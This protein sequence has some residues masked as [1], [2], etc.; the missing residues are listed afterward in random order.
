MA[1]GDAPLGKKKK[2]KKPFEVCVW[3]T[4]SLGILRAHLEK[5]LSCLMYWEAG[6]ALSKDL[7]QMISKVPSNLS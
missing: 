5:V 7:G 3:G 2:R 4:L 1:G 6:S